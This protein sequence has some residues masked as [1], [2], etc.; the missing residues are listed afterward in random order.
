MTFSDKIDMLT[1]IFENYLKKS[2]ILK[3]TIHTI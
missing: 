1:G 2:K 3:D